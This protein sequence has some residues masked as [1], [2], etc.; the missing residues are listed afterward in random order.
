ML[1][2]V[3]VVPVGGVAGVAAAAEA[4]VVAVAT[5]P[6]L[7][8]LRLTGIKTAVTG[9][10]ITPTEAVV[11]VIVV[12]VDT[13][14]VDTA[15]VDTA[16]VVTR[17][18]VEGDLMVVTE[19]RKVFDSQR[20]AL[21]NPNPGY[22][23]LPWKFPVPV[24]NTPV[25]G[26]L[27]L[28]WT[29]WQLIGAEQWVLKVLRE[30]YRLQ[31]RTHPSLSESP[32]AFS[33]NL[34]PLVREAKDRA[35]E[36][37]LLK[38]AIEPVLDPST[39][40]FYS[41]VFLVPKGPDKWRFI[42]NLRPL[43]QFLVRYKF[44]MLTI[45][46]LALTLE[47]GHWTT[48]LDLSDAFLH[49]PIH[50]ASRKFLRFVHKGRVL[51]FKALPFGLSDS[52]Y[53]FTRV[54]KVVVQVAQSQGLQLQAYID[55]WLNRGSHCAL[56]GSNHLWLETL[57]LKLGLLVNKEKSEPIP[58]QTPVFVGIYWDLTQGKMFPTKERFLNIQ[59]RCLHLLN[60][61]NPQHAQ[62][63]LSL[64]GL[65]TSTEKLVP[66]GRLWMRPL[67]F[68][69]KKVF[70]QYRDN[71]FKVRVPLDSEAVSSLKWWS[72]PENVLPGKFLGESHASRQMFTDASDWGWGALID[73]HEAKGPWESA[74]YEEPINI[75]E[76][77][78]VWLGLQSFLPLVSN[79]VVQVYSDNCTTVAYLRNQGG[80]ISWNMFCLTRQILLWCKTKG[81]QIKCRYIPGKLN[82]RADDLSRD[83]LG[84]AESNEILSTEW[85]LNPV[86]LLQL[87]RQ[88]YRPL[89][90]LFATNKNKCLPLYFSPVRD[91]EAL[92]IDA[93][94]HSWEG[95]DAYAFPPW[96]MLPVVI[97]KLEK[98]LCRML[99]IAPMW[100]RMS[101]YPTLCMLSTSQP[102]RL[103]PRSNLL[104]QGRDQSA[105]YP[106]VEALALHAWCLCG[107]LT[108][109]RSSRVPSLIDC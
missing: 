107:P 97:K 77:R 61:K 14:E 89:V 74:H 94:Y 43:N 12:V 73:H 105:V 34:N 3:V 35:I 29:N 108:S 24:S 86:I 69:M 16:E 68:T 42:I 56:V 58:T 23:T 57:C 80:T 78:A 62:Y 60:S 20:L 88:A 37:F 98:S 38:G 11:V 41:S 71:S 40:G 51:Q 22:P 32:I 10:T 9:I 25:G 30:G 85:Q 47:K 36:E 48:S 83:G 59:S 6:T 7:G 109:D 64:L 17:I 28:F 53:V 99:L 13:A 44:R 96:N 4:V 50:P 103:P 39:P 27:S 91:P 84:Q 102:I 8:V 55:D 100:T 87:W 54:I 5:I 66:W 90:D 31:F 81:I 46:E 104:V 1:H 45:K 101:W 93:L 2:E 63:W 72:N 19:G 70:N 95:L 67:Q 76:L 65:M 79:Q 52:P 75:R 33:E 106:D 49:I 92:G 18:P 15:E 26:R 21:S 82:L